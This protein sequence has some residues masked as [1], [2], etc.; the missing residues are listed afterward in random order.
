MIGVDVALALLSAV[1]WA[2]WS[3]CGKLSTNHGVPS[4]LLAFAA[5]CTSFS[6]VTLVYV[7]QRLP[8]APTRWGVLWALLSGVCGAIGVL[9]FSM[10]IKLGNTALV[11]TLGATYPALTVLLAPLLLQEQFLLRHALGVLLVTLGVMLLAR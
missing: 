8:M 6:V 5:S 10:A 3:I 2:F 1:A 4:V 11:V 7:W 9:L